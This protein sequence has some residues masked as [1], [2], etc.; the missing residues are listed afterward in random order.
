[1]ELYWVV[2]LEVYMKNMIKRI[3]SMM[4]VMVCSLCALK[5]EGT[6]TTY[7][8][9]KYVTREQMIQMIIDELDVKVSSTSSK[10][11]IESAKKIGLLTNKTF[12]R[13]DVYATKAEIAMLLVRADEF[14]NGVKVSKQLVKEIVEKRISDIKRVRKVY[15]PFVAKAYALGYIKGSSNGSYSKDRKF[16]PKYKVTVTYAKQLVSFIH[17]TKKRHQISPDGQLI[18]TTNLPEFA[19]YYPYI[20]ESFPNEYYDW[21]FM[22]MK[23]EDDEGTLFGTNK[24]LSLVNYASP[25]DFKKYNSEKRTWYTYSNKEKI[26]SKELYN[27]CSQKWESNVNRYLDTVFNV[28]YK[29]LR[30]NKEWYDNLLEVSGDGKYNI[31]TT[32]DK[33]K[34]YIEDAV[35]NKTIV[36]SKVIAVDKSSIYITEG[37]IYIRAY[38]KYCIKASSNLQ[39]EWKSPIVYTE[40]SYPN[41]SNI[42]LGKWRE[43][44]YDVEVTSS[45]EN[46]GIRELILNDF[47]YNN[48]VVH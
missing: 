28:D 6:T 38:V 4:L 29:M 21:E 5:G 7:G 16:N 1:M 27:L 2:R 37:S 39:R 32:G 33:I 45:F 24:F 47:Y 44:F 18:R 48:R 40:Y 13:Y 22:F 11:Y 15:Q 30:D 12:T 3:I 10:A 26:T 20:L 35:N 31:E 9:S 43:G 19:K 34:E 41:F 14:K 17:N 42:Q 46:C 36:E 23:Y 8:A 25:K